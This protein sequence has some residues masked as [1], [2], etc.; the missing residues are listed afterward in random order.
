MGSKGVEK[1]VEGIDKRYNR[2]FDL[3]TFGQI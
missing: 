1:G 2:G 3:N